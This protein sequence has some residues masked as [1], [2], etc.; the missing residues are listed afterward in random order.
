MLNKASQQPLLAA[1]CAKYRINIHAL[2]KNTDHFNL[3]TAG[4]LIKDDVAGLREFTIA[5]ADCITCRTDVGFF[6]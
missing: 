4:L 3:L 6:C 1:L 5:D 2:M